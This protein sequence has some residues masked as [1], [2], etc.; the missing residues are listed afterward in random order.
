LSST[1]VILIVD[2]QPDEPKSC[3]AMSEQLV[4]AGVQFGVVICNRYSSSIFTEDY[5]NAS[6]AVEVKTRA[7]ID[8]AIPKLMSL[9]Q[10]RGLA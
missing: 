5:Y 1:T 10:E 3:K 7:D 9:I 8:K 6:V 4:A 2:G